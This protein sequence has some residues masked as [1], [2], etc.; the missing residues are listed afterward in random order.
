MGRGAP[1]AARR[2]RRAAVRCWRWAPSQD[3][4]RWIHLGKEKKKKRVAVLPFIPTGVFPYVLGQGKQHCA[5]SHPEATTCSFQE[6]E[7]G[8]WLG[9]RGGK[10]GGLV[11]AG[12]APVLVPRA[13][14]F[15]HRWRL[16]PPRG[17]CCRSCTPTGWEQRSKPSMRS[18]QGKVTESFRW[19][20][21]CGSLRGVTE[22]RLRSC[23]GFPQKC[24]AAAGPP[25]PLPLG[26]APAGS[27]SPKPG[28]DLGTS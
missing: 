23:R 19:K 5:G 25:H 9:G 10:R 6:P 1:R 20:C 3:L 12:P 15:G 4:L 17:A 7:P 21:H 18:S 28:G 11:C 22:L 2:G 27:A 14:H 8:T 13:R 26:D 16:R 24:M